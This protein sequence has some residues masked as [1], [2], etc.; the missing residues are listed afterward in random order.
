MLIFA[1]RDL[2]S[3]NKLEPKKRET[4]RTMLMETEKTRMDENERADLRGISSKEKHLTGKSKR[5]FNSDYRHFSDSVQCQ[6]CGS[7]YM[8][9]AVSGYCQRCQ[10]RAEYVIR[11]RPATTQRA[12]A[13]GTYR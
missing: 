6:Y 3:W 1:D 4:E 2:G 13:R 9:F 8:R 11:E 7:D 10:Q 12:T 5:F